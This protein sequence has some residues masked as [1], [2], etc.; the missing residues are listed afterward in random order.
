MYPLTK[1][2]KLATPKTA[3]SDVGN[4]EDFADTMSP[5]KLNQRRIERFCA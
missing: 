2:R 4:M 3:T 1:R 5:L